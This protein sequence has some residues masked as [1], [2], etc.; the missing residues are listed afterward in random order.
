MMT[1][2][3]PTGVG[4]TTTDQIPSA[5]KE[6]HPHGRGEDGHIDASQRSQIETP[7]RAWG[8]PFWGDNLITAGGN[9]P[10]GVGKTQWRD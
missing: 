3:T 8:R 9:T 1:R 6:K 10:T 5:V 7:P 2:N 4:K